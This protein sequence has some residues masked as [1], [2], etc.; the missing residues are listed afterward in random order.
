MLW[1]YE[2]DSFLNATFSAFT[3][4]TDTFNKNK[5]CYMTLEGLSSVCAKLELAS[6]KNNKVLAINVLQK[7]TS[8]VTCETVKVFLAISPLEESIAAKI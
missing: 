4:T 2:N 6:S 3:K 8:Y 1:F 7:F 5:R